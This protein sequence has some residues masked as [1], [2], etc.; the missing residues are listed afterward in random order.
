MS[1]GQTD[2]ESTQNKG[3]VQERCRDAPKYFSF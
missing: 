3:W 2:E 1:E